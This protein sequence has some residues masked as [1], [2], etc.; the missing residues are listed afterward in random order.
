MLDL[1]VAHAAAHIPHDVFALPVL[2]QRFSQLVVGFIHHM[3][4]RVIRAFEA[5]LIH[6][7]Q[8]IAALQ[9]VIAVFGFGRF[10]VNRPKLAVALFIAQLVHFS[11]QA[12]HR[13]TIFVQQLGGQIGV[14]GHGAVVHDVRKK[15]QRVIFF[16]HA[17]NLA[18][19]HRHPFI[20]HLFQ[21]IGCDLRANNVARA[22]GR[23][24]SSHK[25]IFVRRNFERDK[26]RAD[27]GRYGVQRLLGVL[28]G[29]FTPFN[30]FF[31]QKGQHICRFHN[32]G[33]FGID[34]RQKWR[35]RL[36]RIQR[37]LHVMQQ[38]RKHGVAGVSAGVFGLKPYFLGLN[39]D[40]ALGVAFQAQGFDVRIFNVFFALGGF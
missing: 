8:V 36:A 17:R 30:G 40:Q 28:A 9:Q 39:I 6:W 33:F 27:M 10:V 24:N 26:V 35:Q 12:K 31:S 37:H 18:A 11:A 23:F 22:N 2:A 1:Q 34:H 13:R 3:Q 4:R 32:G 7:N 19:N 14:G 5:A 21:V 15:Q 20:K 38:L 29:R 25:L 16:G